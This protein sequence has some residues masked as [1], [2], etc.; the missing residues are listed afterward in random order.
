MQLF[1]ISEE[2]NKLINESDNRNIFCLAKCQFI[3]TLIRSMYVF[4]H[5]NEQKSPFRKLPQ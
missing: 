2:I 4:T 1:I 3:H 5:T